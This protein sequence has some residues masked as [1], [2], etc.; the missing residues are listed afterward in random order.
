[1]GLNRDQLAAETTKSQTMK[2]KQIWLDILKVG[3]M[4][5]F[6]CVV[7]NAQGQCDNGECLIVHSELNSKMTFRYSTTIINDQPKRTY[8]GGELVDANFSRKNGILKVNLYGLQVEGP[9]SKKKVFIRTKQVWISSG[10]EF[11][12]PDD[13]KLLPAG[14]RASVELRFQAIANNK[15]SRGQIRVEFTTIIDGNELQFTHRPHLIIN[16]IFRSFK[17]SGDL[18]AIDKSDF[19]RDQL[20][21]L[22]IVVNNKKINNDP[23]WF[24]PYEEAYENTSNPE[25]KNPLEQRLESCCK[26]LYEASNTQAELKEFIRL[27]NVASRLNCEAFGSFISKATRKLEELSKN[28]PNLTRISGIDEKAWQNAKTTNTVQAYNV[29]LGKHKLYRY[30][31]TAA[32]DKINLE[33]EKACNELK[34]QIS[35]A[36]NNEKKVAIYQAYLAKKPVENFVRCRDA[37]LAALRGLEKPKNIAVTSDKAEKND[38]PLPQFQKEKTE[39]SP[40]SK[41]IINNTSKTQPVK[42]TKL[43]HQRFKI[44]INRADPPYE[45]WYKAHTDEA[46][47]P[48]NTFLLREKE[49]GQRV[50]EL[51]RTELKGVNSER[52]TISIRKSVGNAAIGQEMELDFRIAPSPYPRWLTQLG[53]AV[54]GLF[55]VLFLFGRTL[56]RWIFTN[57]MLRVLFRIPHNKWK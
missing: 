25:L 49:P 39:E 51:T 42:L 8:A 47:L 32:I 41:P 33:D 23:Q 55:A 40:I 14:E 57:P 30:E 35:K 20:A 4:M 37:V 12:K 11:K 16:Y 7:Q 2:P 6:L 43:N 9:A 29:Y 31:A 44:E 52:M 53:W 36:S 38:L 54:A 24:L 27:Y 48:E 45:L 13:I 15:D 22:D 1:M 10:P 34:I 18:L 3:L 46:Y 26:E 5:F 19:I 17:E 21:N 56:R 50:F 28:A